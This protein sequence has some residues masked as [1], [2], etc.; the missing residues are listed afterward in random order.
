MLASTV[1]L[2]RVRLSKAKPQQQQQAADLAVS[3]RASVVYCVLD[4]HLD[5]ILRSIIIGHVL[6]S[7]LNF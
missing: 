4:C 2:L 6:E 1:A 5:W 7:Q 3:S